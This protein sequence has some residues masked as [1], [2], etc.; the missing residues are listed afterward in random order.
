MTTGPSSTGVLSSC[1][2]V[3]ASRQ[4]LAGGRLFTAARL[5]GAAASPLGLHGCSRTPQQPT[6]TQHRGAASAPILPISGLLLPAHSKA[7]AIAEALSTGGFQFAFLHV[8]AVDDTGHDFLTHMKVCFCASV[9]MLN[10]YAHAS[11]AGIM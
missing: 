9:R 2:G 8:K 10:Q 6:N 4:R 3:L 5:T 11:V 7:E 1:V